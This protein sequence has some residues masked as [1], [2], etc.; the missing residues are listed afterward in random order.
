MKE[1]Y[2]RQAV[3]NEL[4]CEPPK[5]EMQRA[6][7]YAD[8]KLKCAEEM[9]PEC[10]KTYRSGWYRVLLVADLVRQ[11]AFADFTITLCQLSKYESEGGIKENATQN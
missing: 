3:Y 11:L 4:G 5:E 8:I 2:S 7:A 9:Q 10:A 1:E 6:E